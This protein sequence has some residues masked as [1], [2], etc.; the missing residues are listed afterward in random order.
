MDRLSHAGVELGGGGDHRTGASRQL[1]GHFAVEPDDSIELAQSIFVDKQPEEV[2]DVL[3]GRDLLK[4]PVE[5][6][7]ALEGAE[8]RVG[9]GTRS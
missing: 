3:G 7:L 5:D 8:S 6:D 2:A 1:I 9:E 4:H